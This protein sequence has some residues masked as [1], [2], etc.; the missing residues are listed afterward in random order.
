MVGTGE[1]KPS[2]HKLNLLDT[3][4]RHF[5]LGKVVEG[6]KQKLATSI[7]ISIPPF[8]YPLSGVRTQGEK[9]RE[10]WPLK[11]EKAGP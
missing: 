5:V 1:T 4:G 6:P 11:R 10:S 3:C 8:L 9:E 2:G 7:H